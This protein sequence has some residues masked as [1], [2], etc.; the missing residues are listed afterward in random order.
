MNETVYAYV[1]TKPLAFNDDKTFE[2]IKN[3]SMDL[4]KIKFQK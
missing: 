2:I 1:P 3:N 4:V